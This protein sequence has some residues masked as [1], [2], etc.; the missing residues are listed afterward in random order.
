MNEIPRTTTPHPGSSSDTFS[1]TLLD[2]GGGSSRITSVSEVGV[3]L[4]VYYR[5][6]RL[7]YCVGDLSGTRSRWVGLNGT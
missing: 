6:G 2:T 7:Q 4:G 1:R 5:R 3:S